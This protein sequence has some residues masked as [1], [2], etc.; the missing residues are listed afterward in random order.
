MTPGSPAL[1]PHPPRPE[2]PPSLPPSPS[3]S[4]SPSHRLLKPVVCTKSKRKHRD[5]A[6]GDGDREAEG[7]E[8][9]GG[10]GVGDR[11]RGRAA[12]A[13]VRRVVDFRIQEDRALGRVEVDSMVP[14]KPRIVGRD[15]ERV[16][17]RGRGRAG[18]GTLTGPGSITKVG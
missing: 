8:V 12:E 5:G 7:I 15:R 10:V 17:G 11:S 3:P 9:G 18:G 13:E 4:P 6:V 16:M 14:L 1:S 2:L